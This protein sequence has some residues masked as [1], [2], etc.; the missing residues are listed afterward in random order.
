MPLLATSAMAIPLSLLAAAQAPTAPAPPPGPPGPAA[1]ATASPTFSTLSG[2]PPEPP[3]RRLD[4]R[5]WEAR[6]EANLWAPSMRRGDTTPLQLRDIRL[7][8]PFVLQ[9]TWSQVDAGTI[10]TDI[11]VQGQRHPAPADASSMRQGLPWGLSAVGIN[12]AELQG[13]S[14]KWSVTWNEQCW[15]SAVD[16]AAAARATWPSEWPEDARPALLPEPGIEA[17]HADFKAFVD[18]VTGSRLREVTPWIA[19]KELVRATIASYTNI[20]SDGIRVENG[21]PRG[22]IFNGA[23]ASMSSRTGTCH[24]VAAACVA[25]LRTAGIPARLVLGITEL[26]MSTGSTKA[27]FVSWCELWLP[28]AGWAPFSPADLRSSARGGLSVERPWPTFG[29][30]DELNQYLPISYGVAPP[31]PGARTMPYPAGYCWTARGAID[32][33]K[34]SDSV[35]L[36]IQS[37]GRPRP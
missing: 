12:V 11:W 19:A 36:Q 20:D 31:V 1:P 34:A 7:W 5:I 8:L 29:T 10:R 2:R 24:D 9:S 28:E 13:Q 26:Q 15:A 25:V 4:P 16:E 18:R 21:F 37:R 27:R 33:A 35:T 17:G 3:L 14:L 23:H 30:W 32:L 6:L 22:I